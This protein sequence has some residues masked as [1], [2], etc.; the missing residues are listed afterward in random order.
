MTDGRIVSYLDTCSDEDERIRANDTGASY[1]SE[2][3]RDAPLSYLPILR[4]VCERRDVPRK[5][6]RVDLRST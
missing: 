5:V 6:A 4:C 1:L 2:E 3:S